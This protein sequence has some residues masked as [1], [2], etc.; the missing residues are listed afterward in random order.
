MK[1]RFVWHETSLQECQNPFHNMTIINFVRRYIYA[2]RK[3]CARDRRD[4]AQTLTWLIELRARIAEDEL[5]QNAGCQTG[6]NG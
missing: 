5:R 6:A 3:A 4:S 2:H 1:L